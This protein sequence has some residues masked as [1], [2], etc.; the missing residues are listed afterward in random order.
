[1]AAAGNY[2]VA[3]VGTNEFLARATLKRIATRLAPLGFVQI[4]RSVMINLRQVSYV[5]RH[6]RGQFCFVM[7]SG[8][9]LIS[10]RERS[11]EIR[12][13]LLGAVFTHS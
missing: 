7:R 4:E 11:G 5:E 9:R 3:H 6:D 10:S 13:L 8:A 2:V 1:M 12:P